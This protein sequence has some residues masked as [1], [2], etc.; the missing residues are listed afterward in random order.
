MN[1]PSRSSPRPPL[2][3]FFPRTPAFKNPQ[4]KCPSSCF[5][6]L[7]KPFPSFSSSPTGR[8]LLKSKGP[9]TLRT[10]QGLQPGGSGPVHITNLNLSQPE[11]EGDASLSRKTR[12]HRHNLPNELQPVCPTLE[13]SLRTLS[14][15][16]R[17][18]SQPCCFLITSL[19]TLGPNSLR[20]RH[21]PP[22]THG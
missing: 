20:K 6:S 18:H 16:L 13:N 22:P 2:T 17:S 19:L 10:P 14:G 4:N 1:I 15:N 5:P 3:P 7:V 9:F 21:C 12:K 8:H 11:L